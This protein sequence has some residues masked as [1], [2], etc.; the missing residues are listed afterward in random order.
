MGEYER[1]KYLSR[2]YHNVTGPN[3]TRANSVNVEEVIEFLKSV[4]PEN[5]H[6]FPPDDLLLQGDIGF[7]ME[8]QFENEAR[9]AL[10]LA[11]FLSAFMQLVNHNEIFSGVR[12]VDRPLTEDQMMGE[13]LSIILGNSRV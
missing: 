7:G 13:V 10:R 1:Q 12:V 11:N 5:C 6:M 3:A 2:D 9:M 4:T 8:K